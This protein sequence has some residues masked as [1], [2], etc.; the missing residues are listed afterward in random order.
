[1]C[2]HESQS[3][4]EASTMKL[5]KKGTSIMPDCRWSLGEQFQSWK[6]KVMQGRSYLKSLLLIITSTTQLH[7]SCF[8]TWIVVANWMETWL[9][10]SQVMGKL[11]EGYLPEQHNSSAWA[12]LE[13]KQKSQLSL[14]HAFALGS[15]RF[16]P[17]PC[18]TLTNGASGLL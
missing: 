11:S 12:F 14:V 1:M 16:R 2:L 13:M 8:T 15:V 3:N 4:G 17:V 5:L 7:S 9:G 18:W 10:L 6:K